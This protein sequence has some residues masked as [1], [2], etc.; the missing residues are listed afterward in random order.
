MNKPRYR[1]HYYPQGGGYGYH[2]SEAWSIRVW[3]EDIKAWWSL[4][5][6]PTLRECIGHLQRYL[7]QKT[8]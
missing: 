7:K 1:A 6:A 2:R 4:V 5:Y 3:R 8:A